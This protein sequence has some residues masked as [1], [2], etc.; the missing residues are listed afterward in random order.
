MRKLTALLGL[1]MFGFGCAQ[2]C[3]DGLRRV[4]HNLGEICIPE[5][6]QRIAAVD[7]DVVALMRLLNVRPVAH[8]QNFY[9][10][11]LASTPE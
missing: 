10:A 2:G 11:W 1:A 4:K 6:P 8:V 9:E 3:E 7:L 5:S